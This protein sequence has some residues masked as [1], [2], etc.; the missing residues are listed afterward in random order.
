MARQI[1]AATSVPWALSNLDLKLMQLLTP[2]CWSKA[3]WLYARIWMA[4]RVSGKLPFAIL[5]R[6]DLER[7]LHCLHCGEALCLQHVV[8]QCSSLTT[9]KNGCSWPGALEP[10]HDY[11]VQMARMRSVGS[12]IMAYVRLSN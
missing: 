12:L 4:A 1:T 3:M 8:A 9:E 2:A 11:A 10:S 7:S 5:G 6:P